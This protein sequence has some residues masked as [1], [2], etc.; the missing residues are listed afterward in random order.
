MNGQESSSRLALYVSPE[1]NDAWSGRIPLPNRRRTDGPLA[2]VRAALAVLRRERKDAASKTGATIQLRGGLHFLAEPLLFTHQDS[3]SPWRCGCCAEWK[4]MWDTGLVVRAYRNEKPILSGGRAVTGWTKRPLNG[5]KVWC[6]EIPE[7]RDGT[8]Y[9]RQLWVNGKRR[10]RPTLP[11]RGF[12]RVQRYAR[13]VDQK[14]MFWARG[15]D[16]FIYAGH[17]LLPSWRNL[18]D[19]EIV[20]FN[21][22]LENRMAIRDVRADERLAV[23]DRKTHCSMLNDQKVNGESVGACYRVENV[24]EALGRPGEWYLD[25]AEGRLYYLPM[26][27]EDMRNARVIAPRLDR[28]LEI[29]GNSPDKEPAQSV[30]FRGVTF[31]HT[32]WRYPAGKAGSNQAACDVTGAV[33]IANAR[34]IRFEDCRL[35]HLGSYGIECAESTRDIAVIGCTI[36]DTGAGG[37]K[38]WHGCTRTLISDNE[39]RDGGH[40]FASAVGI[41]IGQ[42]SGNVV[43]HNHI[44]GFQYSGIS[45]GWDWYYRE[46]NAYGNVIAY[47]HIHHIG[48]RTLSDLAGIYT[49]GVSPGSRI[50]HNLIHDIRDRRE[51]V[52]CWGIYLDQSSSYYLIQH[53]IVYRTRAGGFF[54]HFGINNEVRN[55]I[56]ALSEEMQVRV[57]HNEPQNTLCFQN[58]IVYFRTGALWQKR[59]WKGIAGNHERVD[60][61]LYFN[62]NGGALD[63]AG[64]TFAQWRAAGFDRNGRVADPLFNDPEK[65]D[66]RLNRK[67]PAFTL[68]FVEFDLA[69]VGP[70]RRKERV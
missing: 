11:R 7:V 29:R 37:V 26:P 39:L 61:N 4:G 35:E 3:G 53:N 28:I 51:G 48:G 49:L 9:F 33:R 5:R 12:Y 46:G 40:V 36:R 43:R 8:W 34:G 45:V 64:M 15:D 25:R 50:S 21:Y 14:A 18:Q 54:Q 59:T 30:C 41:L 63:F 27:G 66:F 47:N 2:T 57:S 16:R 68:G 32:E 6:A 67:S 13:E 10:S 38:V 42:S 62:A 22:W 70:R 31:A 60:G 65:G 55:N 17:D 19:V 58:N 1:G 23:L 56:F 52:G 24:F 44:H 69:G 20:L